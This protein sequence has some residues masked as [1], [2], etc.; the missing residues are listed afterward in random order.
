VSA[1]YA[2]VQRCSLLLVLGSSLTVFSGRRFVMRAAD[3]GIPVVIVNEGPTRGDSRAVLKLDAPL[4]ETLTLLVEGLR[5][6]DQLVNR[7]L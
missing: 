3:S 1:A 6:S 5:L 2:W 4:G 7:A